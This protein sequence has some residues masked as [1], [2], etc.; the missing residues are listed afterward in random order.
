[1]H[2][3]QSVQATHSIKSKQCVLATYSSIKT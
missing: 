2:F 1:M 3:A